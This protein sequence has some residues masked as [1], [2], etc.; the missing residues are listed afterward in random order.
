MYCSGY[1]IVMLWK[2]R[3]F[4]L[5]WDLNHQRNFFQRQ[6]NDRKEMRN[7]F[8]ICDYSRAKYWKKLLSFHVEKNPYSVIFSYC[9][10]KKVMSL[11]GVFLMVVIAQGFTELK[12]R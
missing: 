6:S 5:I 3:G 8:V 11:T 12:E 4:F 1:Y 7:I 10:K 9:L 2:D